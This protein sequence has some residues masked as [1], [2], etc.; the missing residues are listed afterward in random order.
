MQPALDLFI[1]RTER[2]G[3]IRPAAMF[4]RMLGESM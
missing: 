4:E 3:G 2:P 1:V